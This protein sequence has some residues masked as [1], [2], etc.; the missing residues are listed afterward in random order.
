MLNYAFSTLLKLCY[1]NWLQN[2]IPDFR[3]IQFIEKQ[4]ILEEKLINTIIYSQ[5]KL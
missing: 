1:A 5:A 4:I 2:E 3:R